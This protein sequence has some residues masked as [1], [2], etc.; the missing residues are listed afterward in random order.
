M[1]IKQLG[2]EYSLAFILISEY[3]I[4]SYEYR[5]QDASELQSIVDF[6]DSRRY[7]VGN[8]ITGVTVCDRET[9]KA[10]SALFR[11]LRGKRDINQTNKYKGNSLFDFYKTLKED[12]LYMVSN[13]NVNLNC[14]IHNFFLYKSLLLHRSTEEEC[15]SY[16]SHLG[17]LLLYYTGTVYGIA[18]TCFVVGGRDSSVC[19]CRF[20]GEKKPTV[21]FNHDSHAIPEAVG[22]TRLFCLDEC[23]Q[24]NNELAPV[25][26][27]FIHFMDFRRAT[28]FI[29]KKGSSVPP[30]IKGMNF[31][32]KDGK[33]YVDGSQVEQS[34]IEKGKI[35]LLHSMM[36]TDQGLYRAMCKF[37]IDLLPA[38]ELPHFQQTI[39][40][41]RGIKSVIKVPVIY[42]AYG[43]KE[44]E[45]PQLWLFLNQ[46][47][48]AYSPY[49]TAILHVCD[50]VF[51]FM[52][53]FVDVDAD[54]F[55]D[56]KSL[57]KH[58]GLFKQC[59]PIPWRAWE[60][61]SK[62]AKYPHIFI[63]LKDCLIETALGSNSHTDIKSFL[64]SAPVFPRDGIHYASGGVEFNPSDVSSRVYLVAP[65]VTMNEK[66]D[67][68]P[69]R[70]WRNISVDYNKLNLSVNRSSGECQMDYDFVIK[71]SLMANTYMSICFGCLFS[72]KNLEDYIEFRPR[73]TYVNKGFV[74]YIWAHSLRIAEL[75]YSR[76]REGTPY[77]P[78]DLTGID[79]DRCATAITYSEL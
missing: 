53:P 18:D 60:V 56:D 65:R 75:Y 49:C 74:E 58:W 26:E 28:N 19:R 51:M 50:A 41:V 46:Q 47:R 2:T 33:V 44:I 71:D 32:V 9:M 22:N 68:I 38:S 57:E 72:V 45:Q 36:I 13:E 31:G 29:T 73:G 7:L 61:S 21:S 42:H 35:K 59:I 78:F 27:H 20:C 25:E 3:H 8:S 79:L 5:A 37:V 67:S 52:I 1:F 14:T 62:E 70:N 76:I 64:A 12:E 63:D 11:S 6:F 43:V 16:K 34:L 24:C 39:A 77:E 10:K 66:I 54:R 4:C 23:D 48:I 69:E 15:N 40:W 17:R 55:R 30:D